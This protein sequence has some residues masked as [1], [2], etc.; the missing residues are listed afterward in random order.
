MFFGFFFEKLLIEMTT[1]IK[2]TDAFYEFT[3]ISQKDVRYYGKISCDI[4]PKLEPD[5]WKSHE[6][7]TALLVSQTPKIQYKKINLFICAKLTYNQTI[8]RNTQSGH[9]RIIKFNIYI[10][11]QLTKMEPFISHCIK[12]TF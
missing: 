4:I 8:C 2:K 11:T 7:F 3:H 1:E 10:F 5:F 6:H 12:W 9:M